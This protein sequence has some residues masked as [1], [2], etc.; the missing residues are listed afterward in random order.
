MTYL[1][2]QETGLSFSVR[3]TPRGPCPHDVRISATNP[4]WGT[5]PE[6]VYG[7][8]PVALQ[9]ELT[10]VD[11]LM[12]TDLQVA[13]LRVWIRASRRAPSN[14]DGYGLGHSYIDTRKNG[15]SGIMARRSYVKLDHATAEVV[16]QL[17]GERWFDIE[18]RLLNLR[19]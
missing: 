13:A 1:H 8:R 19:A 18:Q 11:D 9:G 17:R 5:N 4:P 10:M 3:V 6:A 14:L 2:P 15:G 16:P 7:L 12:L